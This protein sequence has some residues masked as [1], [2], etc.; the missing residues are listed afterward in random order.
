MVLRPIR[1]QKPIRRL[2][3]V[4]RETDARSPAVE[5]MLGVL[6]EVCRAYPEQPA[7]RAAA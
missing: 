7:L 2:W 3:A 4:T 6:R 1:G 5:E